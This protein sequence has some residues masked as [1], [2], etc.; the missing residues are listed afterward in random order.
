MP[1]PWAPHQGPD[2][3]GAHNNLLLE[4]QRWA[5]DQTLPCVHLPSHNM[6]IINASAQ[7]LITKSYWMFE[8][9]LCVHHPGHI[10]Q[11]KYQKDL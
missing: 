8:G 4:A 1:L 11:C 3:R 10:Q 9:H 5:G 2:K 7:Q 6:H